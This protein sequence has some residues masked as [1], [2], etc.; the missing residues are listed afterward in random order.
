MKFPIALQLYSVRDLLEKDL[1]GGL[2]QVKELGYD[3]VELAGL[4]DHTAAEVKEILDRVGIQAVSA[5]VPFTD[6]L[7]DPEGVLSDYAMLGCRYVAIPYVSDEYRPGHEGFKDLI[8]GAKVLGEAAR[9]KGM[10]LLYHNHDFEFA[11]IDGEYALDVLYR[12]VPASLLETELDICWVNISGEDPASYIRKYAGRAPVV[13]LKDFMLKG[14]KP[15]QMYQLLGK[16]EKQNARNEGNFEFRPVGSGLQDIPSVL[17]ASADAGAEWV[18]V[19]QD[20]PS[21]GKTSMECAKL[22]IDYLRTL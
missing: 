17:A 19:E 18:V 20:A 9:K 22:S 6:M 5:H 1:E 2:K 3:G 13:H 15:E 8:E 4:Y 16:E 21:M 14:D 11:L 10:T 12:E 7:E